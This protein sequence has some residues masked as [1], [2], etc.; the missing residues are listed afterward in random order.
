MSFELP[1]VIEEP[2]MTIEERVQL[3]RELSERQE[4]FPFHGLKEGSYELL[5]TA[6]AEDVYGMTTPTDLLLARCAK[7][8]IK[9]VLGAH[10]ESGNAVALPGDSDDVVADAIRLE[11][12]KLTVGMDPKLWMLIRADLRNAAW[13]KV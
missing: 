5:K 7:H 6:D 3:A 13:R 9:V 10:P 4:T 12:L 2:E 1:P 8:G 11:H